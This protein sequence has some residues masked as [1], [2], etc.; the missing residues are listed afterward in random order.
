VDLKIETAK[1][2]IT[3][4]AIC[5]IVSFC[6][7]LS[8]TETDGKALVS[9][10]ESL[11][12]A[13]DRDGF[14]KLFEPEYNYNGEAGDSMYRYFFTTEGGGAGNSQTLTIKSVEPAG[15]AGKTSFEYG[16]CSRF[17]SK[18]PVT[19]CGGGS[20]V[21]EAGRDGKISAFRPVLS[22]MAVKDTPLPEISDVKVNGKAISISGGQEDIKIKAGETITVECR[23][24]G[25]IE[26]V[27]VMLGQ[28]L[29]S[30]AMKPDTADKNKFEGDFKTDDTVK[31]GRYFL[32]IKPYTTDYNKIG[33]GSVSVA[34]VPISIE[35]VKP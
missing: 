9:K 17:G 18:W 11:V 1:I 22:W 6:S 31:T 33:A 8:A 28:G 16:R 3:V 13:G 30:G 20:G 5:L 27:S 14:A 35:P 2:T 34:T 26:S 12:N 32:A 4:A 7:C 24:S 19:I 15:G 25:D 10:M 21:I 29:V 23:I